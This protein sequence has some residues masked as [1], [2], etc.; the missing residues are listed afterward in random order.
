[1]DDLLKANRVAEVSLSKLNSCR[2][3]GLSLRKTLLVSSV[4]TKSQT[5]ASSA[6]TCVTP[7]PL[8]PGAER[9]TSKLLASFGH[10]PDVIDGV[11]VSSPR[12][13]LPGTVAPRPKSPTALQ[14][15]AR[16]DFKT[17]EES[18]DFENVSSVL[19]SVWSDTDF[20]DSGYVSDQLSVVHN[21]LSAPSEKLWF[22]NDASI[23]PVTVCSRPVS[24]GKRNYHEAFPLVGFNCDSNEHYEESKRFKSSSD[25]IHLESVP[26]LC[27]Y[28]SSKNLQTAPFITYMFGK[29]FSEPSNPSTCGDWPRVTSSTSRNQCPPS[30]TFA[31][32][33]STPI[34]AF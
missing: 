20:E 8:V 17:D 10:S 31:L 34:L 19:N 7:F 11:P 21:P 24:P 28:L 3:G 30:K 33:P 12:A 13:T 18:M 29:G 15:S 14:S 22:A 26:G 6:Y 2:N 1:M 5:V 9:C 25:G 27:S 23:D 32:H 16:Q 4:L